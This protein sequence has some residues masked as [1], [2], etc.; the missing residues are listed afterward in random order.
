[1]RSPTGSPDQWKW[2]QPEPKEWRPL[3]QIE[4][5]RVLVVFYTYCGFA[6]QTIYRQTDTYK[7]GSYKC[8][9]EEKEMAVGPI[10]FLTLR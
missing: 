7:P 1:V 9:V 6:K 4:K 3:V 5:D 10:G 2:L 8:Q